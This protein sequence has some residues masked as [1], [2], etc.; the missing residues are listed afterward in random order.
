M[1]SDRCGYDIVRLL[2]RHRKAFNGTRKK[3]SG[4]VS[5]NFEIWTFRRAARQELFK[6]RPEVFRS[7]FAALAK[8]CLLA[9]QKDDFFPLFQD[10]ISLLKVG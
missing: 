7:A 6:S 3:R 5:T 1:R 8:N 4:S 9:A 2:D 10:T